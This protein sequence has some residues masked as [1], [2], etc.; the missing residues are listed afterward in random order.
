[1]WIRDSGLDLVMCKQQPRP[2]F[3]NASWQTGYYFLSILIRNIK[4][5]KIVLEQ[6]P[7]FAY[8]IIL[9]KYAW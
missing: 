4:R 5:H 6:I 1:M 3:S 2:G 7:Q 8:A 9:E